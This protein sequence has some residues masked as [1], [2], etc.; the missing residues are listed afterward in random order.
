MNAHDKAEAK[1]RSTEN[2][3]SLP[4]GSLSELAI[5]KELRSDALQHPATILPLTLC[6][7]A[8]LYLVL[9]SDIFGKA[10]GAI[11]LLICSG[12]VAIGSF[13]W[14]Y[15]IRY[16]EAYTRRVKEITELR[17]RAQ[18]AKEKADMK[19]LREATQSGLSKIN[20]SK[21][22]KAMEELVY[23]YKELQH[24]LDHKKETDPLSFAHIPVLAEETYR[25]GL[26][27]LADVLEIAY[28]IHSS[29]KERLGKE[30]EKLEREIGSLEADGTQEALVRI[31]KATVASHKE[32]LDMIKQQELRV[33]R[34]L[35]QCDRC[36]ASLHRTRIELASLKTESSETSVSAVTE[37]LQETI[38]QAKEVQEE[39]KRLGY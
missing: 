37:T 39:L 9:L 14:R 31:K 25:Q 16:T 6:I 1:R 11:I 22:L 4:V 23:E 36:E 12:I 5:R 3:K 21:G 32:R 35:Y 15:S 27:V 20:S 29:D 17:D 13:L 34:L 18:R 28:V 38:N 26:S 7:L 33:D 19:Q 24:I 10:L 8:I 30:K 2:S